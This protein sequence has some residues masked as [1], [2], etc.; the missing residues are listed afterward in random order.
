MRLIN[1]SVLGILCLM[2]S[3]GIQAWQTTPVIRNGAAYIDPSIGNVAPML[4]SNRPVAHLPNQMIRVFPKR[5]DH[6]DMQITDFPLLATNVIT[7]QTVFGIKAS[8]GEL[9]DTA[10]FRRLTYDHD[11]ETMQPW[12][13]SVR[14]SDDNIFLEFTPGARGGIYRFAFPKTVSRNLL[15]SH[16]YENG[17]FGFVDGNA[18]TGTEAVNDVIHSQK[19]AAY[20]YGKFSG[21]PQTGKK[22]GDKDWGRYTVTGI[23]QTPRMYNGE[24]AWVSYPAGSE[25]IEFRY[26][27][28]FVSPEQAKLNYQKEIDGISFDELKAAGKKTWE[29]LMSQVVV[30]GGTEAQKR[31]FYTALYRCFVRMV[32]ISEDGKYFSAYDGQLHTD[33]RP[34]YTD[35]YT[36]GN[37]LALHPLRCILDP[38]KEADMLESYVRMYEQSGWMPDYPRHFGDRPGMFGFHSAAMF[39]DAYRKGIRNFNVDKALEGLVK[40]ASQATMLPSRNGPKGQL[41]EFFYKNGYY[42]ALHPGEA[43]TDSLVLLKRGQRRS[44]VAI[45]LGHSYDSWALGEFARELGKQEVYKTYS[46]R[47]KNY[48]LLWH[49][50]SGMFVPKDASGNWIEIDQSFGGGHAGL[51]YYNENNGWIY[52]WHVQQDLAG[53]R[54]LMGGP[55]E[56]EKKLDLLFQE[57]VGRSK[58]EFWNKFP[59]QTGLIGQFGMGN[60]ASFFIPYLY[61]YTNAAWKTQKMTRLLLDTWFQDNVFG[62][63]GDEDGGAMSAFAVFSAMGFYPTTPGKPLYSI[64]SPL[65]SKVSIRLQNGKQ[66]ILK[67]NK[68]SKKN[69]YIQSATFNGKELKRLEFTHEQLMAG[70]TLELQMGE[71]TGKKWELPD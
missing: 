51:D 34:F 59:D 61:N 29:K 11:F 13:Y 52:L 49:A 54:D 28:S 5:Q 47:G 8:T 31:S 65:F 37:Y 45:T 2:I 32:N 24:R 21:N 23:P 57:G 16:C 15:L 71:G 26:A 20:L 63:S 22:P 70:G 64:T 56:M 50:K 58:P 60:Q 68:S 27:I 4:N 46:P 40:S 3:T 48:N 17:S 12:Y 41:E 69:K 9:T 43:E 7:P 10:W 14:L 35:D 1:Q 30:E 67:A 62:V 55:A 53:L 36:W 66:F 38:Q 6:L 25:A 44:A 42:P 19:G 18:V 33:A 39:L